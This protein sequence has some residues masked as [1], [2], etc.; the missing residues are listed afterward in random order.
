MVLRINKEVSVISSHM[1]FIEIV[2][3]VGSTSCA[4][5][6]ER[7]GR[8]VLM[9]LSFILLLKCALGESTSDATKVRV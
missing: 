4:S 7:E 9:D 8:N 2:K 6:E 1:E 5:M 3:T